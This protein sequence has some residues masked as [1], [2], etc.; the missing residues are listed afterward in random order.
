MCAAKDTD[1]NTGCGA[2]MQRRW[3][4][5]ARDLKSVQVGATM[6]RYHVV[7]PGGDVK[8]AI[9]QARSS[10]KKIDEIKRLL[11]WALLRI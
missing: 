4:Q 1:Y 3:M 11:A 2:L 5:E 10:Q 6:M 8:Y 9:A 7:T